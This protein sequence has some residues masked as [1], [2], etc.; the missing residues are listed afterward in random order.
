M[1]PGKRVEHREDTDDQRSL[2]PK[3]SKLYRPN[4]YYWTIVTD[5]DVE[6]VD[7]RRKLLAKTIRNPRLQRSWCVNLFIF[8]WER[9]SRQSDRGIP[10]SIVD[11]RSFLHWLV[12]VKRDFL[13]QN[14]SFLR[15][16]RD[17]VTY[18]VCWTVH[19]WTQGILDSSFSVPL[20]FSLNN[21]VV[22][23]IQLQCY[24]EIQADLLHESPSI[25]E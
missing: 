14:E 8:F 12:H 5:Y 13:W 9:I 6:M 18:A 16:T 21:F 20:Q 23:K 15:Y 17:E 24:R 11:L 10:S 2:A 7:N 1:I 4:R 3:R 25:C 22:N 19:L